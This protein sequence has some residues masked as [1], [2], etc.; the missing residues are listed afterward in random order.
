M[1]QKKWNLSKYVVALYPN[2]VEDTLTLLALEFQMLIY[3]F[4]L[5]CQG[6]SIPK[7]GIVR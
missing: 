4:L 6:V 5:S 3:M 7:T 2:T 1:S